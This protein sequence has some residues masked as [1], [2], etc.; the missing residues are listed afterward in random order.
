MQ[1]TGTIQAATSPRHSYCQLIDVGTLK[2]DE[3]NEYFCLLGIS[4]LIWKMEGRGTTS[5]SSI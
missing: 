2:E 3:L 1:G 5:L 4:F